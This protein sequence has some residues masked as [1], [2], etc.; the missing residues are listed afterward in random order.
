M[1]LFTAGKR[2]DLNF[3]SVYYRVRA[4]DER[5]AAIIAAPRLGVTPGNVYVKAMKKEIGRYYDRPLLKWRLDPIRVVE[6]YDEAMRRL[7][8][9]RSEFP[10]REWGQDEVDAWVRVWKKELKRWDRVLKWAG[11]ER[12]VW[13]PTDDGPVKIEVSREEHNRIVAIRK[14]N[15]W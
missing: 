15:S 10:L 13:A 7:E 4:I 8:W 5:E 9:W 12:H 14:P 2:T 11:R 6:K 1:P 3:V